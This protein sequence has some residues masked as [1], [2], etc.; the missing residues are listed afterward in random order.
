M[1]GFN[2]K[3]ALIVSLLVSV[4]V[5]VVFSAATGSKAYGLFLIAP[6]IVAAR[7]LKKREPHSNRPPD[8]LDSKPIHPK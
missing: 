8:S 4:A 5:T 3:R 2:W 7:K 6:L 1:N